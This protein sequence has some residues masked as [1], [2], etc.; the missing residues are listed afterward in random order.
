MF[1]DRK[2]Y[3]ED[4]K[5]QITDAY[6]A[7]IDAI[8][9]VIEAKKK[10]TDEIEKQKSL[11]EALTKLE[12]TRNQRKKLTFT[13]GGLLYT[14]DESAIKDA[15]EEVDKIKSDIEVSSLEEQK[16][17]LETDK[18][19]STEYLDVLIKSVDEQKN[20]VLK[21]F[22]TLL[23]LVEGVKV[24]NDDVAMYEKNKNA[25]ANDYLNLNKT[26]ENGLTKIDGKVVNDGSDAYK[27]YAMENAKK[28]FSD[29][30]GVNL[31]DVQSKITGKLMPNKFSMTPEGL[32]A[33]EAGLSN[34][35]NKSY[36]A[37][38]ASTLI[39]NGLTIS[40]QEA[41]DIRK[42]LLNCVQIAKQFGSKK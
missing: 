18:S 36:N 6:D 11:T 34:I 2:E 19:T 4:L 29:K 27:A 33:Y 13:G 25:T 35:Y 38:N 8:D 20:E 5:T 24:D 22:D 21:R 40:G 10:E 30:F 39:I 12:D 41:D 32:K 28:Y 37:D 3:Y 23:A 14:K 42:A 17:K 15:Q 1:D 31:D 26:T 16:S 7:E 9:K